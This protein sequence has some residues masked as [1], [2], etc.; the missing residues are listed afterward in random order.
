MCGGSARTPGSCVQQQCLCAHEETLSMGGAVH[1]PQDL[2]GQQQW[3]LAC[4]MLWVS[5]DTCFHT[6]LFSSTVVSV[7]PL[8]AETG[9]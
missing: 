6:G 5:P 7:S 8:K 1:G 9:V 2:C 4:H 3:L